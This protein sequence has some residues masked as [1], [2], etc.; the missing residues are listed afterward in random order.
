VIATQID[1]RAEIARVQGELVLFRERCLP[2]FF[3][4]PID[5][6]FQEEYAE[7]VREKIV[8][9]AGAVSNWQ[10]ATCR[11]AEL[12][13]LG[14]LAANSSSI[15]REA[16]QEFLHQPFTPSYCV[17][18]RRIIWQMRIFTDPSIC[19][20]YCG[21]FPDL[22]AALGELPA[23][24]PEIRRWLMDLPVD[25]AELANILCLGLPFIADA[26]PAFAKLA[27]D[28]ATW[29]HLVLADRD[30]TEEL[31]N[32]R[33][34]WLDGQGFPHWL[35]NALLHNLAALANNHFTVIEDFLEH[36]YL[37]GGYT[38]LFGHYVFAVLFEKVATLRQL[39]QERQDLWKAR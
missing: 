39:A 32:R 35:N 10:R 38:H 31:R 25:S 22:V 23:R 36:P 6:V 29:R 21:S 13:P 28:P 18:E 2:A 9:R 11:L 34:K 37:C 26:D 5:P 20:N 30:I 8:T 15:N 27:L 1:I 7:W 33:L 24:L 19:A 12:Q 3:E 4:T 16:F 14:P 17:R